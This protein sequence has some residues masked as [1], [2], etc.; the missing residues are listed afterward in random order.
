MNLAKKIRTLQFIQD[1]IEAANFYLLDLEW[2]ATKL[3]CLTLF[4]KD[5]LA[6]LKRAEE[7]LEGCQDGCHC[8]ISVAERACREEFGSVM[9]E[10]YYALERRYQSVCCRLRAALFLKP[11]A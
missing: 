4:H 8:P 10:E 2:L 11:V 5:R 9:P 3:E 6:K 7:V 1:K